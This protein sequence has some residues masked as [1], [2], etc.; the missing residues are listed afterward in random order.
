MRP[1]AIVRGGLLAA[2]LGVVAAP[3]FL[4]P[5][6]NWLETQ[7]PQAG[8]LLAF[9]TLAVY[10]IFWRLGALPPR[11]PA[12]FRLGRIDAILLVALPLYAVSTSNGRFFSS[13]DNLATRNLGPLLVTKRTFDLSGVAEYRE[14]PRHYST[15][16]VGKRLLP[17]FP[18][19]TG[20]L[21]VPYSAAS[22]AL[23]GGH[24]TRPLLDRTE[25]H[26]A[27]VLYAAS[28]LALFFGIRRRF[29]EGPALGAALVFGL[30]T[31]A[32][33]TASQALWSATGAAFCLSIALWC[34]LPGGDSDVRSAAGGLAAAA[35]FLCRPTALIP[36]AFVGLAL[37]L[38]R[39]RAAVVYG[40]AAVV[41]CAVAAA[42]L[43]HLYGHPLGGYGLRNLESGAWSSRPGEGF[44]G[45]LVSPSRGLLV[46]FP[47]LLA[48]PLA[49]PAL[50]RDRELASWFRASAGAVLSLYVLTSL[51]AKWWGGFSL[52]PRLLTEVSPFIAFLTVPVWAGLAGRG[53][54]KAF[55]LATIA[56]AAA[57]Q[58][59]A[60]HRRDAVDWNDDVHV[61]ANR[62]AL[63]QLRQSQLL[64]I[65]WPGALRGPAELSRLV[66]GH[67]PDDLLTGGLDLSQDAVVHGMLVVRGWARIPGEDL[68]A[69][70]LVD[71]DERVPGPAARYP[72]PDVCSVLPEMG[73]CATA[74]FEVSFDP[75]KGDEGRHVI[76][77]IFLSRDGRYRIYPVIPFRWAP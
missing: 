69:R 58:V 37:L 40:I 5:T 30:A 29:G 44:L 6:R 62:D 18:I 23:S 59:L 13:G 16:W 9:V 15:I 3:L 20:L 48:F 76:T 35:A 31:S 61:D 77:A 25:K 54:A 53:W 49:R 19:G 33:T 60:I 28:A 74:G 71:G 34:V 70:V 63:W 50:S 32:L 66:K 45:N 47:Y 36:A 75:G 17:A 22:L 52:G 14:Y 27:A 57:T 4:D 72:R 10:G 65:W 67:R 24:V 2:A 8:A 46:F 12:G 7:I 51:F 56:F 55:V 1:A 41:G 42:F 26:L 39:R 64:A 43:L 68:E 73:D 11:G 21:S 38:T